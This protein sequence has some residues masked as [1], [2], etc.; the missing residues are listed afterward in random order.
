MPEFFQT[1]MGQKFYES[2]MPRIAAALEALAEKQPKKIVEYKM[3]AEKDINKR[4]KEG[5]ELYGSPVVLVAPTIGMGN[6]QGSW[7]EQPMVRRA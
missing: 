5:W 3:V 4:L 7:M 2:T 6:A 1:L